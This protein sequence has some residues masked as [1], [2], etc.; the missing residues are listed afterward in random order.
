MKAS[1]K[2]GLQCFTSPGN[3]LSIKILSL[4]RSHGYIEGFR[5]VTKKHK[6]NC[7]TGFPMITVWLKYKDKN[8]PIMKDIRI[9]KN[10]NSHFNQTKNT[11][12]SFSSSNTMY[13]ISRYKGYEICL[14]SL[15]KQKAKTDRILLS[16]NI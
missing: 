7:Y 3:T 4:L 16:F 6:K 12:M 10:T 9:F 15:A 1:S 14:A 5:H 8:I 13:V 11:S 2:Q